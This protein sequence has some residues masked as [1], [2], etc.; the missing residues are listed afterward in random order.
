MA[1]KKMDVYAQ[2]ILQHV[3]SSAAD[4]LTWKQIN[5]T[6]DVTNLENAIRIEKIEVHPNSAIA[7]ELAATSDKAYFLLST[8]DQITDVGYNKLDERMLFR[9]EIQA[10]AAPSQLEFPIVRDFSSMQGGGLLAPPSR[11][12]IGVS[13]AGFGGVI[14]AMFIVH[15]THVQV[16]AIE[17]LQMMVAANY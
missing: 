1:K 16:E 6:T 5:F 13:S 9:H 2:R 14:G 3:I 8:S 15:F 7:A 17:A 10:C 11:L 12:F 4:T